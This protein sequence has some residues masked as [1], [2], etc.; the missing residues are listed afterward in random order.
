MILTHLFASL[1]GLSAAN[2]A[3][4]YKGV[5]WSSVRVEE[6]AG[7]SYKN[8]NGNAQ[9]LEKILVDNGINTVRQRVWVNPSDGNYNLAYNIELA[10]RAKAA[11]LGVYIDFHYSDTWADPAH[12]TTPSGWPTD[13]NNLSWKLY[14]YTLDAANQ[15]QAAGVQPTI[16]SI[17]NEIRSGLLWPTGKTENW[18]NIARLLHSAAWAIKDSTL[19]PKPKIMIHLDNGWWVIFLVLPPQET[20]LTALT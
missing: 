18:A 7:V 6:R 5:D 14:N 17:G 9:P 16:M 1:V 4:T 8:T 15:F 20:N 10:K 3:L 19:S 2:A 12:Q 13:I 11:G